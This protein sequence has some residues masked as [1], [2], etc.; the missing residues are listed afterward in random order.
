[1]RILQYIDSLM[2]GGA[3][4]MCVNITNALYENGYEVQAC[5]SR[6]AGPL[7]K[8]INPG[9]K[10]HVLQKKSFADIFAYIRFIK[11][12]RKEK[13]DVIHA[14]SSSVYWAVLTKILKKNCKVIWHDHLGKREHD[15]KGNFFYKLI[16][17]WVDAVIAV[18]NDQF[19]WAERN[20]RIKKGRIY[21]I[22]N[23]PAMRSVPRKKEDSN[24]TIVCLANLLP[25]KDHPTL[26]R[27]IS[28][29]SENKL[30]GHLR[31]IL[32][33]AY[34]K[35]EYFLKLVKL[36]DDLNLSQVIEIAGSVEDTAE[37]L[38]QADIGAL[39][40][41]SEGFPVSLLE[42]GLAGLPVVVTDVGQCSDVIGNG[43][44]GK[45][46]PPG[47]YEA[48]AKELLFLSLNKPVADSL[49]YELKKQI[50]KNYGPECFLVKY[51]NLI[52][53]IDTNA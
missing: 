47:D 43:R 29:L 26:V 8:A 22:N 48:F 23:F 16:S 4:R 2:A 20:M 36:I 25:V 46:V 52:K 24:F 32:A 53:T 12:L 45:V 34:K 27:A 5:I 37:L 14:H 40:S 10:L 49:G 3:E 28:I 41:V 38:S 1:M 44:F 30:P 50:Q 21:Q 31:V 13:I 19:R 15:S 17:P 35:D 7:E 42:Y 51:A 6:K 33:G 18:N 39:S 9:I 11:I